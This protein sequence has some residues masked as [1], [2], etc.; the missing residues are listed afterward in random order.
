MDEIGVKPKPTLEELARERFADLLEAELKLLCALHKSVP[1][2]C[3]DPAIGRE[4]RVNNPRHADT[5]GKEYDI[6]GDLIRWLCVEPDAQSRIDVR[7]IRVQS[8][9]I[10]GELD[11][12]FVVVRFPLIF[13]S[14]KFAGT[15]RL[16]LADLHLLDLGGSAAGA[17]FAKGAHIKCSVL[18]RD[19]FSAEGEV[20]LYCASVRGNLTCECG[21]F[22]NTKCRPALN[23]S[24]AKI[25]GAVYLHKCFSAEGEVNLYAASVGGNLECQS[26]RF[27]NANG[28]AINAALAKIAGHVYLRDGFSAEGEV[29]LYGTSIGGNLECGKGTFNKPGATALNFR[30]GKNRTRCVLERGVFSYRKGRVGR[31]C[32][33]W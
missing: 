9:R 10:S 12:S 16:M 23:T 7:G 20:N 14:C 26:G 25:E 19:G 32:H 21:S 1:A 24:R 8:A 31:H 27:K 22:K 28:Y 6:R 13:H 4:E 11:L 33:R 18:L 30:I 3:G 5:W 15:L 2:H 17:V 29:N